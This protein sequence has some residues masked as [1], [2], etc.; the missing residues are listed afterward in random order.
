MLSSCGHRRGR[1]GQGKNEP[2][3]F[4]LMPDVGT[5]LLAVREAARHNIGVTLDFAHVLCADE[6]LAHAAHLVAR[7]SR[8]L[9]V[10]LSDGCGKR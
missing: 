6:M 1:R 3:A 10:H 5:T 7:H 2:R 9:G 4:A 8:L